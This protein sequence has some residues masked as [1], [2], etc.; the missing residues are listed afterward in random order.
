MSGLVLVAVILTLPETFTP[1][2]LKWKAGHLRRFTQDIRYAGAIEVRAESFISRLGTSLYRPFLLTFSEPIVILVALYM[3]VIYII[4]FTF[5]DGYDYIYGEIHHTSEGVTGLCFLGIAIG[6]CVV[7]PIVP[8]IYSWAKKE[9]GTQTAKGIENPR[10]PPE[11]RLWYAML[12]GSICIP[13]SLFWMGWTSDSSISIWSPLIASVF[14]GYGILCVFITS[15]QYVIDSYEIYAA[16]A[17]VSVTL[18]RY[19]ACGGAV[20][21]GVP[22]YENLGVHYTLTILACLSAALVPVPYLFYF[23]GEKVRSWSKYAVNAPSKT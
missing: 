1:I 7:S 23:Y 21:Y 9:I 17:L 20:I 6:L 14:F 15:Y 2:I 22:M 5:L 10:L 8:L 4:L 12:G 19:V 16:S 18:L 11:F 3:T 13:V